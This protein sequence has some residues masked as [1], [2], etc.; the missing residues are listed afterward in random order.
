MLFLELKET[1]EGI[2]KQVQEREKSWAHLSIGQK[3]E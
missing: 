3:K 2:D 1:V